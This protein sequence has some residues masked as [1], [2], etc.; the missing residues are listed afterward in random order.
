MTFVAAGQWAS[1]GPAQGLIS[2]KIPRKAHLPSNFCH[3][4]RVSPA[5]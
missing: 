4:N 5:P 3:A 1:L 2:A